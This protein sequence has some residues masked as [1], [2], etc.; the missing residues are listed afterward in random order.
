MTVIELRQALLKLPPWVTVRLDD[1]DDAPEIIG[2][3]S[4]RPFDATVWLEVEDPLTATEK[5]P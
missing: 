3:S 2:V 5:K 1:A 4:A